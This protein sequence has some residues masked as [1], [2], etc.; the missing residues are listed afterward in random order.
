M[1]VAHAVCHLKQEALTMK[2]WIST[3]LLLAVILP[4]ISQTTF[5]Q[6]GLVREFNSSKKP[7]ANTQI[8]FSNAP[9]TTSNAAGKFRLVFADRK[10]GDWVFKAEIAQKGYE[11]VNEKALESV[12]LCRDTMACFDVVV[13]KTGTIAAAQKAYYAL[14]DSTMK[15]H[16]F[17][18]KVKLKAGRFYTQASKMAYQ[19]DYETLLKAYSHQKKQLPQFARQLAEVNEDDVNTLYQY[20]LQLIKNGNVEGAIERLENYGLLEQVRLYAKATTAKTGDSLK[21][22]SKELY[23]TFKQNLAAIDLQANLHLLTLKKFNAQTLYEQIFVFDSTNLD[24]L[25]GSAAFF[26]ANNE[27]DSALNLYAKILANRS[28]ELYPKAQIFLD[29]GDVLTEITEFGEAVSAFTQAKNAYLQAQKENPNAPLVKHKLGL[30]YAKLGAAYLALG[31]V[32]KSNLALRTQERLAQELTT[33]YPDK[34]EYKQNAAICNEKLGKLQ[35]HLG[36]LTKAAIFY[37]NSYLLKKALHLVD[38]NNLQT[39]N[40]W[41]MACEKLATI[42]RDLKHSDK[43]LLYYE[44]YRDLKTALFIDDVNDINA[45]NDLALAQ[46]KLGGAYQAANNTD[47]ALEAYT[48]YNRLSKELYM[49]SGNNVDFKNSLALSFSRLT[50]THITLNHWDK[51]LIY[52]EERLKLNQELTLSFPKNAAYKNNLA[53]IYAKIGTIQTALNDL[54]K[55][56]VAYEKNIELSKELYAAYPKNTHFKNSLALAYSKL[57]TFYKDKK[58]D[59]TQADVYFE[60]GKTLLS[61]LVAAT[62][63]SADYKNNLKW[64]E[65][66]LTEK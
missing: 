37:E 60:Q 47:K 26:K 2:N 19:D 28:I 54:D 11:L 65:E 56:L 57:G 55:A 31:E 46:S 17:D 51:A 13:A 22:P 25:R 42:H 66:R 30:I 3:L 43:A 14:L 41:A 24:I 32:D 15:S 18:E 21:I 58:N 52:C 10:A 64:V 23:N 9:L 61:E 6:N 16:L 44:E 34:Q 49:E 63:T 1:P 39:K 36:D 4:L 38:V 40:E 5:T 8:L 35:V 20:A 48:H 53:A 62:P 59:K 7:V 12:R 45:K 29:G 50:E 27:P 33:L